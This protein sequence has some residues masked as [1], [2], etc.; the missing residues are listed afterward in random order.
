M[1]GAREDLSAHSIEDGVRSILSVREV[2]LLADISEDK[3]RKDIENRVLIPI[4]P[5]DAD[6]LFF[7][8][9][10][11]FFLAV[12][13]K[14]DFLPSSLRKRA[15]DHLEALVEP[16]CRREF[17]RL[18]D[19]NSLMAA[20]RPWRGPG[21]LLL[22]CDE[23]KLDKYIAIDVKS[24]VEDL[25]PCIDLYANGLSRIEEREGVLGG[26]AVFRGTRV[27][28]RH[29]GKMFDSGE[30]V[31]EIIEDYPFL[32]ENDVRFARLFYKAHPAVGRPPVTESVD[33]AR[34]TS[35]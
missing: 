11:V 35:A 33:H 2:T 20:K 30:P 17:Y 29:I 25:S 23:V 8:W 3:V 28:V 1:I 9:V 7:R 31:S 22:S 15:L 27:S 5:R 21:R 6:R 34:D 19:L 10:D 12:V 14:S 24:L 4:R 26:E 18:R 13:Y 32:R 16:A